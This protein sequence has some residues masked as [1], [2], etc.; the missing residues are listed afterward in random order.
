MKTLIIYATK[1]GSSE[2]AA[3][4]LKEKLKG[5]VVI[6]NI[7]KNKSP[8]I[9]NFDAIIIGGSIHA[10]LIQKKIKLFCQS[11]FD[12]LQK[13]HLGLYLC[14]MHK[15]EAQM[16]FENA[17]SEELRNKAIANG[18]FGGEFLFEKMNW[19]EKSIVKK[20]AGVNVS[21]S[22]IDEEAINR[23]A[24]KFNLLPE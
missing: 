4:M 2:K 7:T 8:E 12:Y 18:L 11:N 20:V 24:E 9:S 19:F 14:C 5:E 22:K 23:F 1:H 13:A 3:N 21:I 17:Y 15:E 6:H 16:Q 10:G